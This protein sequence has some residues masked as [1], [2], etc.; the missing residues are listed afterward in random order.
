[1]T[2]TRTW[3]VVLVETRV[4]HRA[5]IR[6]FRLDAC[7]TPR[8]RGRMLLWCECVQFHRA[9]RRCYLRCC[10]LRLLLPAFVVTC[11]CCY[12]RCCYLRLLLPAF[13][14]TCV[15]C[16]LRVLLPVSLLP[17]LLLRA[18]NTH[19]FCARTP[20]ERYTSRSAAQTQ[21][22]SGARSRLSCQSLFLLESGPRTRFHICSRRRSTSIRAFRLNGCETP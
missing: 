20:R 6:T 16:Y 7:E 22:H 13:V 1:M 15:C 4:T 3:R 12:L 14:V 18:Y 9:H 10:Y 17:S 2:H 11:V 8:N 19:K 5:S 21:K